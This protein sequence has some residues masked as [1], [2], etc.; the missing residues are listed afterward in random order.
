MLLQ[1]VLPEHAP[2]ETPLPRYRQP[3]SPLWTAQDALSKPP[4]LR[5]R[6]LQTEAPPSQLSPNGPS[7]RTGGLLLRSSGLPVASPFN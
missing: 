2:D 6:Y 5:G 1:R 4:V 7:Q 3:D